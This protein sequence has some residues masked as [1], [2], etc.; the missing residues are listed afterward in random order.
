M[1]MPMHF[2][3]VSKCLMGLLTRQDFEYMF[4]T[5]D[6]D[7]LRDM[8]RAALAVKR[9]FLGETLQV[10]QP[11][12][13][14]PAI[15]LT[16]AE[17][18]L[19]CRHCNKSYLERMIAATTPEDLVRECLRLQK[20]GAKGC[21]LSGGFDARGRLPIKPFMKAIRQIK[22]VTRFKLAIHP[23]LMDRQAVHALKEAGVDAVCPEIIGEPEV[24]ETVAGLRTTREDYLR[25]LRLFKKEG[26]SRLAPH[27]C[28]GLNRGNLSHELS[29]L[30]VAA[31][32][33]PDVLV[34][35]VFTPTKGTA[36]QA[37]KPPPSSD[38]QRVAAI[39]RLMMPA[40]ELALGCMRPGG[41]KR[42]WIDAAAISA[43]VNRIALPAPSA[44]RNL[45]ILRRETC[46]VM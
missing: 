34:L 20:K 19:S 9:H 42:R 16:G 36:F 32:V 38:V 11:G 17:C 35:I 24:V 1:M 30:Q 40:T 12:S 4:H 23:G 41:V 44:V 6:T 13:I 10:F 39:A 33:D 21:L 7:F 22:E 18:S 5:Q 28:I 27:V 2:D 43:G 46:C 29:A 31:Q 15:S 26:F 8:A 37:C 45:S 25:V 3:I 14:F